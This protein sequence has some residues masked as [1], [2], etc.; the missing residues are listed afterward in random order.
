MKKGKPRLARRRHR[1]PRLDPGAVSQTR[2]SKLVK[3]GHQ[4]LQSFIRAG[5]PLNSDGSVN[6][7]DAKQWIAD[8]QKSREKQHDLKNVKTEAEIAKLEAAK[9]KTD[10]EIAVMK[11]ELHP[12]R[13]CV[14]SLGHICTSVWM[15]I[16]AMPS[17]IQAAHPEVPGLEKTATTIVNDA[18]QRLREF[19]DAHA[20]RT[21]ASAPRSHPAD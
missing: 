11:G 10:L 9:R 12:I 15:E 17:R 1:K 6:V 13:D 7:E 18:A 2:F 14:A 3:C 19:A 8:S 4:K 20:R 5:M 21:S 16:Q